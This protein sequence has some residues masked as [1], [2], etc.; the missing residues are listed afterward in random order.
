MLHKQF[1]FMLCR[2]KNLNNSVTTRGKV[3]HAAVHS[4]QSFDKSLDQVSNDNCIKSI[5][6]LFSSRYFRARINTKEKSFFTQNI[7]Y[8]FL[9]LL[10]SCRSSWHGWVKLNHWAKQLKHWWVHEKVFLYITTRFFFN[11]KKR[12]KYCW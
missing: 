2:Y 8:I 6:L 5:F 9:Y 12:C 7:F 10:F 4:L 1:L 11:V 3:L